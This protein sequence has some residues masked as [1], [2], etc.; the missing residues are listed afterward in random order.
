[1]ADRQ[2]QVVVSDVDSMSDYS[3]EEMITPPTSPLMFGSSPRSARKRALPVVSLAIVS[4][5]MKL[6]CSLRIIGHPLPHFPLTP[7]ENDISLNCPLAT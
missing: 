1:M 6:N 3:D 5:N 7:K 4:W 2:L